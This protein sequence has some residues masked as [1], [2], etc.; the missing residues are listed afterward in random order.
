MSNGK[1]VTS[2]AAKDKPKYIERRYYELSDD[3][4]R[5][6]VAC[7]SMDEAIEQAEEWMRSGSWGMDAE[8]A[9]SI[10]V[11][12][13]IREVD[14]RGARIPDGDE[15]CGTVH[16]DPDEPDCDDGEHD[17]QS[18]HEIVGGI[19]ENPGVWGHGGG[20]TIREICTICGM[21]RH[22]DTWA[23]DGHGGHMR[24]VSYSEKQ[25]E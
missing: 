24:S 2:Q 14:E 6:I 13:Y 5:E 4:S 17:W 3:G 23:D 21:E 12:Y 20:V 1:V 15:R 11:R 22:T 25:D 10:E 18:P 9:S 19:K 7:D 16:I 8:G